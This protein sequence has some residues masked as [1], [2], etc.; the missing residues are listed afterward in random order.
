MNCG[1]NWAERQAAAIF[2]FV[3]SMDALKV[4]LLGGELLED[5]DRADKGARRELSINRQ[6]PVEAKAAI[7]R[8][9]ARSLV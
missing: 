4:G 5:S 7:G 3:S 8:R 2:Q 6:E 9:I 1:P